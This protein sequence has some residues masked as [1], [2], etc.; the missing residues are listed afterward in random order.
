[1]AARL[2]CDARIQATS[3]VASSKR[4]AHAVNTAP[5]KALIA[6]L[7]KAA[8]AFAPTLLSTRARDVTMRSVA[9]VEAGAP[10]NPNV[11]AVSILFNAPRV[12]CH[13]RVLHSSYFSLFSILF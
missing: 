9:P 3:P 13:F 5:I 11:G 6:P 1:M 2:V 10:V 7:R 12:S 4:A 8:P